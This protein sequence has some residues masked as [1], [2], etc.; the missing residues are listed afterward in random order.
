M[1]VATILI[2][3]APLARPFIYFLSFHGHMPVAAGIPS[4]PR[5]LDGIQ[6]A[7]YVV[8]L[9][10]LI[11]IVY[12]WLKRGRPHLVYL[13]G[14]GVTLLMEMLQSPLSRTAEWYAIASWFYSLA[15]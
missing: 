10:L 6:P 11:P 7:D 3:N 15:G 9:I 12:D 14:G 13:L 2:L 4:P 5:P 8:N 1:L